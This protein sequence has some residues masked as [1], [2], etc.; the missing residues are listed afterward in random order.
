MSDRKLFYL[1]KFK[2][3][4]D[5]PRLDALLVGSTREEI[6]KWHL[7]VYLY[8]RMLHLSIKFGN[9]KGHLRYG[10]KT[11]WTPNLIA[12]VLKMDPNFVENAITEFEEVGLIEFGEDKSG[13]IILPDFPY[14]VASITAKAKEVSDKRKKE[15][16]RQQDL[17]PG[18]EDALDD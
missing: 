4:Y 13:T 6:D 15:Q 8:E 3:F 1:K 18:Y 7:K 12:R 11:P 16:M 2:D 14:M 9:E 5:D 17:P 10:V